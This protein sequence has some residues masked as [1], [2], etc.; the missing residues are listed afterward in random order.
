M[1][2]FS[3]SRAPLRIGGEETGRT[4]SAAKIVSRGAE[5]VNRA[6]LDVLYEDAGFQNPVVERG[7]LGRP[8]AAALDDAPELLLRGAVLGPGL[9]DDVLLDHNGAHIIAPGV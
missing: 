6:P 2:P 8:E 3:T 9:F 5:A 1:R 7:T 4:R